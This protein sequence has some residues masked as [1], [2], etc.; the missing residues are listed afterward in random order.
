[1]SA[2]TVR[3]LPPSV[4]N[5]DGAFLSIVALVIARTFPLLSQHARS[6]ALERCVEPHKKVRRDEIPALVMTEGE[7]AFKMI[8]RLAVMNVV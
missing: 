5:P 1:M 4:R 2:V 6:D 7:P 3:S 8:P